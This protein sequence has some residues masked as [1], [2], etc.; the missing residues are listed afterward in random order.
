M[1][2]IVPSNVRV[3]GL[4]YPKLVG[5]TLGLKNEQVGKSLCLSLLVPTTGAPHSFF[6]YNF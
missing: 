4:F 6:I 2:E 1:Y 5:N 3:G